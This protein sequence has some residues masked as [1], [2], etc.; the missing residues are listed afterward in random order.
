MNKSEK[1]WDSASKN[2][3]KTEER[4]E[5]IHSRSRENTS[6]LLKSDD[7]VLDYGCGTGTA[8]C[9]FSNLVKEID[10]IDIS[11]KMIEVAKDKAAAGKIENVNFEQSDIFD[12][13]YSSHSYDVIL[14]FN[15]L[16]TVASPHD[17][18]ARI[19]ELLKPEGLFISVTPCLGQKMSFLVNL[20]IQLVGFLC[21]FGVIPIPIRRIMSTE[22]NTLLEAGGFKAVESEEIYK[23]ASSYF[24]AAKKTKT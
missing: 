24:V 14:A 3:D 20:Q 23:G 21:K 15:M 19:G 7:I 17:V 16:H 4:F 8:A 9:Q 12:S 22:V 18:I 2:Y 1:F 11:A 5:Y 10:A 6:K 13:K